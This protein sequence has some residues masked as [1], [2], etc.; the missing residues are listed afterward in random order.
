MAT[1]VIGLSIVAAICRTIPAQE[2]KP[3]GSPAAESGK[4]AV[5]TETADE[6]A[7][8]MRGLRQH[9]VPRPAVDDGLGRIY[10]LDV[11]TGEVTLVADESSRG[12]TACGSPTWS[13]DGRRIV[14]DA[15]PRGEMHRAHLKSIAMAG[16]RP[17]VADLGPG[18]CPE[19]S[20]D[21][22]RI[23]FLVSPG[24]VPD[25]RPGVWIM[26]ADGS[27]RH[28]LGADGRPRWSPDGHQ[29]MLIG[30]AATFEITLM[31][32]KPEKSGD[33]RLPEHSI[34]ASPSWAGPGMIV[35]FIGSEGRGDTLALIDVSKP[36]GATVEG[37]LWKKMEPILEVVDPVYSTGRRECIFI[38]VSA[39]GMALYS[40][41]RGGSEPPKRLEPDDHDALIWDLALSPDGRFLL[42][43]SIRPD[44]R[45]R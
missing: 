23:A 42:F 28:R 12:L 31:D 30:R 14:F 16:G 44:R 6:V 4:R 26:S 37:V 45:R 24:A 29:L 19:F 40:V 3:N 32:A 33:L 2:P 10:A 25:A 22:R 36:Q 13:H 9:P 15:F 20:P 18:N 41:R 8:L 38:G 34:Y 7:R 39:D 17:Q 27:G 5:G 21:D 1:T 43:G 35:A 11:Q